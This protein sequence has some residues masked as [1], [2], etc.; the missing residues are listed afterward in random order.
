MYDDEIFGPVLSVVSVDTFDEAIQLTNE[1]QFDNGAAIFTRDG[2]AARQ[3]ECEIEAGMVGVNLSIPVPIGSFSFGGWKSS[4]FG[5]THMY[6]PDS[7]C[8]AVTRF[9]G[10]LER[11]NVH[12]GKQTSGVHS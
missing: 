10:H 1:N 7:I 8:L 3:F 12:H 2:G 6:G 11:E 4:L 9:G 5:D